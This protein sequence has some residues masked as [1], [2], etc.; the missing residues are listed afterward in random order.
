MVLGAL[1]CLQDML[2]VNVVFVLLS[3][4]YFSWTFFRAVS[5]AYRGPLAKF[6]GPRT[7]AFTRF[8]HAF[9]EC[10][11]RR[12]F[13]DVLTD[14]HRRH[15]ESLNAFWCFLSVQLIAIVIGEVIRIGPNE[16]QLH[17]S[18]PRAYHDIYNSQNRWD[19]ESRLYHSFGEDRSSFG[20]LTYNE[21]KSRKDILSK[22]FSAKAVVEAKLL[23]QDKV[24]A[25]C[26]ALRACHTRSRAVHAG[27][28]FRCMTMDVIT[29]LCF[30]KSVD[31]LQ[32]PEFRAPII[33]A[34]DASTP[35]LVRFKHSDL[36]KSMIQQCPP[37]LA[38]IISPETSGLVD[39]QQVRAIISAQIKSFS[40]SP[41][42][43][44]LLPHNLTIYHLLL[45]SKHGASISPGSLYEEAQALLFAGADTVGNTLQAITFFLA[46]D[47][48]RQQRLRAEIDQAWTDAS[49]QPPSLDALERLPFLNAVIKEG[50]RYS[51]GVVAG[52]LRVVPPEGAVI[53]GVDV[54]GG[55]VVSCAAPFV[56]LNPSIFAS[57]HS[58]IPERLAWLE[59]RMTLSMVYH[60]FNVVR[61]PSS[62]DKLEFDD[63]FLPAWRGAVKVRFEPR[64]K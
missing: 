26:D 42:N 28:A 48:D 11:L 44:E 39:L 64:S 60:R 17:F 55:T 61:D 36:Y 51:H 43:L 3:S 25:L 1:D 15:G 34:M 16:Q 37:R 49:R 4:V 13:Y 18:N 32:E 6:P 47:L 38:K 54:P 62:P 59:L 14:L 56:H 19:K 52:L 7:A 41:R 58:F 20:F 31:A 21:S 12:S 53:A 57:P 24:D 29:Y 50:L 2:S 5:T 40:D 33:L 35:V 23:V 8:W 30:G 27:Y 46:Q 63:A 45:S 22:R 10:V 9:V